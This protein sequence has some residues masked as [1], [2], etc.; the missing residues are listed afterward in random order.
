MLT[1]SERLQE[2]D[3]ILSGEQRSL[4]FLTPATATCW[5]ASVRGGQAPPTQLT[6]DA[7]TYAETIG[8]DTVINGGNPELR[9]IVGRT[10]SPLVQLINLEDVDSCNAVINELI[11]NQLQEY[12]GLTGQAC[13]IAGELHYN[14]PAHARGVGFSMAQYFSSIGML[15]LAVTD[16]GQGILRNVRRVVPE[17]TDHASAIDWCMREGHTTAIQDDDWM[18][19]IP[20][21]AM[22]NPYGDAVGTQHTTNHHAGLGLWKL[23]RLISAVGGELALWSGDARL[24]IE[25]AVRRIEPALN[26]SGVL[27]FLRLPIAAE[28]G[29]EGQ[30]QLDELEELAQRLDI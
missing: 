15:E 27:V 20:E 11:R 13:Q 24:R 12:P 9:P 19:R 21:D 23:E 8:L 18:Q 28:A 10:Y 22:Q 14:V 3:R 29:Y 4:S 1:L 16:C 17:I 25:G 30:L 7:V 6:G 26:W 2:I 5:A